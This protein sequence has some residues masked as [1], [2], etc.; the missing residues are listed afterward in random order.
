MSYNLTGKLQ[1]I[2][3]YNPIEGDYKIRL[4]ANESYINV[5]ET[6]NNK[7]TDAVSKVLFNRYPDPFA[8]KVC[9]AF[10]DLYD[11]PKDNVTAGNGSDELIS[12]LSSC[13]FEKEDA[14]LTIE[15][16]FS[17]YA[18]YSSLYELT[19]HKLQKNENLEISV[20]TII[21]YCNSKKMKAVI[22][23]NP[24]NPTSLGI[25]REDVIRLIESV[26]CL[27]IVDEA[28]MDFWDQSVIN[29]TDKYDNLI[30]LKT[31]SKAIGLASIR[32]GFAVACKKI[33]DMLRTVKS[34]YNTDAVSQALSVAVLTEKDMLRKNASEII[35]N[36]DSLLKEIN[37]ICK[38][39]NKIDKVYD[40]V[41]NFVF[42][43]TSFAKDIQQKLQ[44][45]SISVRCFDGYLRIN[46]GSADENRIVIGALKEILTNL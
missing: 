4:D 46:T 22:F 21:D 41:T 11:I 29:L 44:N 33:T 16:D 36:K 24:C 27:V 30:V 34:P 10:A 17:M 40:S 28:Y 35:R 9:E 2:S 19:P 1:K 26:K 42:I 3:P 15:P 8:V 23:S 37:S 13:F 25:C 14:V 18:F 43:K 5:N 12:I 45:K 32:M 31:C 6:L 39:N 7:I 20:D 38:D